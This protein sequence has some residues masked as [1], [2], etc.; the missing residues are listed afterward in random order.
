MAQQGTY[1]KDY[2]NR[3]DLATQRVQT[4]PSRQYG[5]AAK[6]QRAQEAMPLPA[7]RPAPQPGT[8]SAAPAPMVAPGAPDVALN[9]PTQR[10]DEPVTAG[11]PFGPGPGPEILAQ[12]GVPQRAEMNTA[13]ALLGA[14]YQQ[15]QYPELLDLIERMDYQP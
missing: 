7:M 12:Y 5:Q 14:L 3:S 15:Y 13:R 1:G 9:A 4:A 6:Q 8:Q 10:P 2:P 11:L